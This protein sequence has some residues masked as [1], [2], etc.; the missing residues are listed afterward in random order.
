MHRQE[1]KSVFN[2]AEKKS[3]FQKESVEVKVPSGSNSEDW[4]NEKS[5]NVRVKSKY[6]K[7]DRFAVLDDDDDFQKSKAKKEPEK[8]V[9]IRPTKK[10]RLSDTSKNSSYQVERLLESVKEI[11]RETQEEK[12]PFCDE[13]L[14]PMTEILRKYLDQFEKKN[15]EHIERQKRKQR[16]EDAESSFSR[17]ADLIP[18]KRR[19]L[20]ADI[21]EFCKLH[22]LEL[23]LKPLGKSR[24]YP[25]SID[26]ESIEKRIK[27]F[28]DQLQDII[29]GRIQ[30]KF[31]TVVTDAYD[32]FGT[33]KARGA[34][35]VMLRVEKCM[36]GYYGPRGSAAII[37]ALS[38]MYLHSGLL[39]KETTKPLLPLEY[40][41]QV[42]VPE[43]GIRLIRE[44]LVAKSTK[45][46][47]KQTS[48]LDFARKVPPNLT[49]TAEK[50]MTE[51]REYGT[52]MFPVTEEDFVT[53]LSDD[54]D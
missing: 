51:S 35:N 53:V 34:I 8:P 42:L 50:T 2:L 28:Q 9:L 36:P 6:R 38:K 37:S 3:V 40:I 31:K 26:F 52:A 1:S 44:D 16:K 46:K 17:P 43:V 13:V 7:V 39:T 19:V 45:G 10:P 48:I 32:E 12:C 22:R 20:S 33:G 49:E 47:S 14:N 18:E 23:V 30:S 5:S 21:Y 25:P 29:S 15:Q 27:N 24:G 54:K 41:Q 4:L 11:K